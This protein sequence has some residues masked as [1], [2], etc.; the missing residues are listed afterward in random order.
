[1]AIDLK[2]LSPKELQA[3]IASASAQMQEARATQVQTVRQKIENLLSS[4]GLSLEDIFPSHGKKA[5]AKKAKV[6]PVAAKYRDPSDPS[7]TWSGRGRQP[8]WF[9]KALRRRGVTKEMLLIGGA[10][11]PAA[12]AKKPKATKKASRKAAKPVGKR[13][14]VKKKA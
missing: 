2:T 6:G 12:Q 14:A 3:L 1:M 7:L 13:V 8:T 10:T 11:K 5:S 9:V 4:S